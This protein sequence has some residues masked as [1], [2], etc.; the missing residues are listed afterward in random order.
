[1]HRSK[2]VQNNYGLPD[3]VSSAHLRPSGSAFV[4]VTTSGSA[5]ILTNVQDRRLPKGIKQ[6]FYRKIEKY[7]N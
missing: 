6:Q 4:T 1:V 7:Y 5:E 3:K 2:D